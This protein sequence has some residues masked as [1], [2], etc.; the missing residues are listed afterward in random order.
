MEVLKNLILT[1]LFR[2][3]TIHISKGTHVQKL[4]RGSYALSFC[5]SG[6]IT[7]TMH[8]QN[9]ISHTGSAVILPKKGAY[10]LVCNESG[11]F[12]LLSFDSETFRC[13]TITA[14][15]LTDPEA[16]LRTFEKLQNLFLFPENQLQIYS[17]FYDML[18]RLL[19]QQFPDWNLLNPAIRYIESH[20]SESQITNAQLAEIVGLS[21]THFRSLFTRHYRISP[22]QYVL[23]VR[24]EKA[25]QLLLDRRNTLA[26]VAELCGFSSLYHFCRSFKQRTGMTPTQ[27][28]RSQEIFHP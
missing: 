14:L 11:S 4:D 19:R 8:G 26:Q 18:N 22:R 27:Y 23:N 20:L 6:Q 15:P 3:T 24:I 7:Y 9:F 1:K 13:D 28:L 17:V 12:P 2:P 21:E 5:Y 25:K 10:S 16:F